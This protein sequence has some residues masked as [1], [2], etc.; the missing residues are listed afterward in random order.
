VG[1]VALDTSVVVA[2]FDPDDVHHHDARRA[3][4]EVEADP[5]SLYLLSVVV[6][7]ESLVGAARLG[8]AQ[9]GQTKDSMCAAL[10][11]AVEVDERIA[12]QAALLRAKHSWL[13]LPDALVLATAEAERADVV[14][15]CDKRWAKVSSKVQV[16]GRGRHKPGQGG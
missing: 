15:T 8:T 10:G 12:V 3:V 5:Q 6:L 16:V 2:L 14:L 13:R 11:G 7:A 4:S 1:T 9:L